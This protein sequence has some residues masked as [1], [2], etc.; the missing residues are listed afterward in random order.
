METIR[1]L[2]KAKFDDLQEMLDIAFASHTY[3]RFARFY[4]NAYSLDTFSDNRYYVAEIDNRIAAHV[5]VTPV[6]VHIGKAEFVAGAIGGVATLPE[7]RKQGLMTRLMEHGISEMNRE[8]I[9]VAALG[10]RRLRYAN[11]GFET[12]GSQVSVAVTLADIAKFEQSGAVKHVSPQAGAETVE[13][14]YSRPYTWIER[15]NVQNH[16]SRE[17]CDTWIADDGY[18]C[19]S[20]LNKRLVLEEIYG[21]Q[22]ILALAAKIIRSCSLGS[23][24]IVLGQNDPRLPEIMPFATGWSL[25]HSY[26][27]RINSSLLFLRALKPSLDEKLRKCNCSPFSIGL[28]IEHPNASEHLG[29]E[30]SGGELSVVPR[31]GTQPRTVGWQEWVRMAMGGPVCGETRMACRELLCALPLNL[32]CPALDRV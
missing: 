1:R 5:A 17:D 11:F 3:R 27:F 32:H 8:G 14:Y 7:F 22:G 30:Y 20:I 19:G 15:T 25:R 24:E 9:P 18:A 21:E 31:E 6:T 16:L 13:K 29:I 23:A 10:G 28:T 2:R 26:L 12:A 4:T